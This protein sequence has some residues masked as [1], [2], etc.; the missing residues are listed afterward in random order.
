M[1]LVDDDTVIFESAVIAEFIND[2]GNG[3]LLASAPIDKAR[4]RAWIEFASAMLDNIGSL[5]NAAGEKNFTKAIDQLE[6]KWRQL[7]QVLS[8]STFFSGEDFS[9]VDAAFA[10]VFRYL[11]LF[12]QLVDLEFLGTYTKIARWRK[13]LS[14]GEPVKKA[15]GP[16]YQLLLAEFVGTRKSYLGKRAR[17]FLLERQA[18]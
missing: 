9:L 4:Q 6:H 11:D 14:L 13:A 17:A 15:V 8:D 1:L 5:Y 12:E 16:D 18:A 10:P 3:E 2:I 7:E